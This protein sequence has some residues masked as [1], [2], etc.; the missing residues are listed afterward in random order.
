MGDGFEADMVA[1]KAQDD[2]KVLEDV[3]DTFRKLVKERGPLEA[4]RC[5]AALLFSEGS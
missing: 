3:P 2:R 4:V 1:G 5:V